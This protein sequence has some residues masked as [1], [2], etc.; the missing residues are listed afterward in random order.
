MVIRSRLPSANGNGGVPATWT[1]VS[2]RRRQNS[3]AALSIS[4]PRAW[5][6]ALSACNIV[7][8]PHPTSSSSGP[9]CSPASGPRSRLA[10]WVMMLRRPRNHQWLS[11]SS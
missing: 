3:T 6:R 11:S 8:V 7:P 2:P 1:S 9:P 10:S 5:P 4:V